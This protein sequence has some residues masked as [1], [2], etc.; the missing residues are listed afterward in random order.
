MPMIC[1]SAKRG[2]FSLKFADGGEDGIRT[3]ETLLGPTPLAGERLRPLGHLSNA[4]SG[5]NGKVSE[6]KAL[7]A[8]V[9]N[10]CLLLII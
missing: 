8:F 5:L 1:S 2:R 3:H 9:I 7:H 6:H 4:G 10:L